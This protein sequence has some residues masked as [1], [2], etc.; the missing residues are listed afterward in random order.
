MNLF[1]QSFKELLMKIEDPSAR[2]ERFAMIIVRGVSHYLFPRF[3][4]GADNTSKSVI[5][6]V[7]IIPVLTVSPLS[8]SATEGIVR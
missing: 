2:I 6:D 3:S 5:I 4:K 7:K 8:V 1:F